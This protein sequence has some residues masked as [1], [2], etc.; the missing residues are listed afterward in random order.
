MWFGRLL[1]AS[2]S[3]TVVVAGHVAQRSDQDAAVHRHTSHFNASLGLREDPAELRKRD[4]TKYVFM[5]HIVGSDYHYTQA[6]W[7]D[8]IQQIAAKGV[9]AIALNIGGDDWQMTQ[10][11]YAYAAAQALASTT[12]LFFS[13]DFTTNLG[14]SLTD[15]VSRTRQFSSHPWQFKVGGSK[16]M[17]SSYS[18]DC[19]GNAGWQ[20]LKDQTGAY[21]MPF[22]WGLEGN[23]GSYPS[24]DSWYC[25][26]CAWPQG[27]YDK[28]TDDD[29]Y[30][31]S[32]LGTKYATTV[33]MWFFT[34]LS[35][36]NRILRSDDWLLN[37]RWE[38]LIAMRNTLT[39]VEMVTWNDFGES[40]YFGPVRIDQPAGTT[41]A[42]GYPHTAWFDMSQYYIQAFKSGVYPAI[43]TDVI[44]YWARPHTHDAIISGDGAQ[45][46]G[47]DWTQDYLWA[48]AF[49]SS[50][51]TVTLKCGT[52]TATFANQPAGVNKLKIP[53][54]AGKITVSMIKN[55]QTVI[56][57]TDPDFTYVT[58]PTKYNF[59]AFV[60]AAYASGSTTPATTTTATPTTTST[61]ATT[62]TTTSTTATT[63]TTSSTA[64]STA[65][66]TTVGGVSWSYLGCYPDP[67]NPR[68][69]NN[70]I[71]T[72]TGTNGIAACLTTC[73]NAG[74]VYA[75]V[76][77]GVECWCASAMT[78]G[79]SATSAGLCN[80]AC[81]GGTGI[82]GGGNNINIYFAA[83]G[84]GST[85]TTSTASAPTSTPSWSYLGCYIDTANPR[86]LNNGIHFTS[87]T[88]QSV[89]SCLSACSAAGYL[90]GG[91]EYGV[92]CWCASAIS[93]GASM[94]SG[95]NMAC[96]GASSDACGGGNR[97]SLYKA[98]SVAV[99]PTLTWTSL[100]CY[101]DYSPRT[102]NNGIN[103]AST[104]LTI[105]S[106][107]SACGAA[108]Y[109]Y[110]GV[111]YAQECWCASGITS[112]VAQ[113]ASGECNM[114]C[115]G[116]AGQ[117]CGGGNRISLYK[118][119]VTSARR[120]GLHPLRIGN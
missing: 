95:C 2:L 4:G 72:S 40:D 39:F 67:N 32:Q 79:V 47:W 5:H 33:S 16:P 22:I 82:C 71:H 114:A 104:T 50:A 76:E 88:G 35:D 10:V 9:D 87:Q 105:Q 41:W 31:I 107:Q 85:T 37:S 55:G 77:Y 73:K 28:N 18:G 81:S 101:Q 100:G 113:A 27:N 46:D 34:H 74:Y 84:L 83:S 19:L 111:E 106:C 91:T 26:G 60:G 54:A 8:D 49:C 102:L 64:A 63:T 17:I 30:Y 56:S 13:F 38:Q 103:F 61:T 78:A 7:T 112:G 118:A 43:T 98:S 53:L 86:T 23:F 109:H 96:S 89:A 15:I 45:P 3:L 36:K 12:K 94:A 108:G 99:A 90:Y 115:P 117:K 44:Y 97:I 110:A 69:L 52:S 25:W 116:A 29:N 119:T 93:S 92:E 20:S 1:L 14:C 80:M 65:T 6:T 120:R 21:L 62:T 42:D 24:L 48:A 75:G 58:N 66:S 51:C 59:N 11:G 68:T 70:G 57:K